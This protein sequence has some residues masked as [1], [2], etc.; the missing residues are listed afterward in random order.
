[1]KIKRVVARSGDGHQRSPTS[2]QSLEG[3]AQFLL[4]GAMKDPGI[5]E[6]GSQLIQKSRRWLHVFK[7]NQHVDLFI[8]GHRQ[9]QSLRSS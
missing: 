1:M 7:V 9:L 5:R 2:D 6:A 3:L 8:S 4:M